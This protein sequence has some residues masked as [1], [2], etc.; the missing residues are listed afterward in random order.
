MADRAAGTP[1]VAPH[2]PREHFMTKRMLIDGTHPE[3]V[4][5]VIT[6]AEPAGRV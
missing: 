3:E 2:R 5:V 6:S 4:R 1:R